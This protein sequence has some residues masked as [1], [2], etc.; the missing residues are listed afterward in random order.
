MTLKPYHAFDTMT[1]KSSSFR[2]KTFLNAF[3]PL[4]GLVLVIGLFS[5]SAE[6]RPVFFT[7]G[8]AKMILTQTAIVATGA[9][10][11]TL[12]I[13]SGGIDLSAGSVVALTSVVAATLLFRDPAR[14]G[15]PADDP[16]R[17]GHRS[18]QWE[19]R[20]RVQNGSF[21]R[22]S[23]NDGHRPRVA[24]WLANNQTVNPPA[25][26][27]NQIMEPVNPLGLWPLP[28]GVWVTMGLA[29]VMTLVMKYAV[30][31]RHIFAIGSNED[32]ARLWAF[33][34]APPRS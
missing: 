12:I 9:L 21:H 29:V 6:L 15:S 30:F 8:N 17:R 32:T 28:T 2:W 1:S 4:F 31:G 16:C 5:L 11:M 22:D 19:Y 14:F 20:G 7:G 25:N 18:G 10:G 3:G 23:G 27:L 13:I 26:P 33:V 24:K 34:C